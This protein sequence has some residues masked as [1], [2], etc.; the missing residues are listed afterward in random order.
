ML[1]KGIH[2]HMVCLFLKPNAADHIKQILR[3][4]KTS[5]VAMLTK[6]K[7]PQPPLPPFFAVDLLFPSYGADVVL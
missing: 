1:E 7:R 4:R 2:G 3:M 5:L 6:R